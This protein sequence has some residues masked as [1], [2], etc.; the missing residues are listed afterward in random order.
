MQY[1]FDK[2]ENAIYSLHRIRSVEHEKS[3]NEIPQD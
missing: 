2:N 1:I 3:E